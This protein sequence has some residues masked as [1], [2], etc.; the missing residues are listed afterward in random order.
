MPRADDRTDTWFAV[1]GRRDTPT[2]GVEDYCTFLGKALSKQAVDLA[3]VRVDWFERGW[4]SALHQLWKDSKAWSENWVL[5]Q[6]TAMA[7]SRRGFAFGAVIVVKIL[8]RRGVRT[9]V[10]FH[11]PFRQG[12]PRLID[13]LRGKCQDWIVRTLYKDATKAVFADPLSTIFWLP[14]GAPK[15][16]FIPIGANIPES[17]RKAVARLNRNGKP[18]TVAVFCLSDLPNRTREIDDI[19]HAMR[20]VREQGL[21]ARVIFLGR[22]TEPAKSEIEQAFGSSAIEVVNLGVQDG[23]EVARILSESDAMLCVRGPLYP[24]RGSAIAGI[25]CGLPIVA[26]ADAGVGTPLEEAGLQ[27][28]PYGDRDNLGQALVKVLASEALWMSLHQRSLDAQQRHFSWD[29][30]ATKLHEYLSDPGARD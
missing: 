15:A 8:R 29:G 14:A 9:A 6:Y 24:R 16:T 23:E 1:L 20:F 25:A 17:R 13:R 30:I 21:N 4:P 12:G 7:W 19:L 18:T 2:D 26:Y 22:G 28:V 5:L 3:K 27:L 11:E 10:L